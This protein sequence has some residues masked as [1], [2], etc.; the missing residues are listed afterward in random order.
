MCKRVL[1]LDM[2]NVLISYDTEAIL[3]RQGVTDKADMALFQQI[4]FDSDVW[5]NLDRGTAE[6]TDF[7]PLIQKLPPHLAALAEDMLLKHIFA[8]SYMPPIPQ[9]EE[10]VRRAHEKGIP[11]Y[12]L[13][14]AGQ[15]FYQYAK[16]IP[17]LR[18]FTGTFVSS[19]YHLLKPEREIYETFFRTF[20]LA[21]SDC[22]FVDDMQRNIDGAKECGMDGI[23]FNAARE[24]ISVLYRKLTEKGMIL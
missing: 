19:D 1:V 7:I 22:V 23:C 17:A 6:K 11:I 12:L 4:I 2:G 15:D 16:G 21:P 18:Y 24:D 3:H 13:S 20:S 9:T 14:N 10:L 8:Q 5:Q